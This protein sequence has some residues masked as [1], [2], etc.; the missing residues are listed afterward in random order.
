M[1]P[2]AQTFRVSEI[3]GCFI[4]KIDLFFAKKDSILPVKVEI[5]TVRNGY[6][7]NIVLP[8]S[9][10]VVE[11]EDVNIAAADSSAVATGI[12][13]SL[14]VSL[15]I[16]PTTFTFDSPV[17]VKEGTEYAIIVSSKSTDYRIWISQQ[18]EID[19]GGG[20]RT[21]SPTPEGGVLFKSQNGST[22]NSIQTQDI[23]FTIYKCNFSSTTG[24]VTLV[25]DN[26]DDIPDTT[27]LAEDGTTIVYG[28]RLKSNPLKLTN[29]STVMQVLHRSHGMYSTTNNV[30]ITGASSGIT[31]TL[32]TGITA[33]GNLTLT[34][35]TGFDPSNLQVSSVDQMFIKIDNEIIRGTL[36]SLAFTSNSRG[37]DG[38]TAASHATGATIELYQ[39][40]EVPLTEI[41]KTHTAIAN[42]D[43]DSYTVSLTT[44]PTVAGASTI[45]EAGGINTIA[46]E[47][48]RYDTFRT[49]LNILELPNTNVTARIRTTSGTSPS[50]SEASFVTKSNSEAFDLNKNIDLDATSIVCSTINQT[51]ELSGAKSLF[52]PITLVT[53]NR[54][55]S[56][57]ID[58]ATM[59][60]LAVANQLNSIDSSSDVYANYNASTEPEGDNNA[61]IYITKKIA[62]Q[63]PATALKVF[64]AGNIQGTSEVEVLFK[65]LRTDSSDDFDDI[66]YE[67]FNT[68]G[69]PD[70]AVAKSLASTDF[71]DYFYSAGVKD[72]GI[73][74]TLPE[75]AQFA[76]KLVFKGTNAAQPPR[77]KDFRAIAL[78][79]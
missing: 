25:N 2:L 11:S 41:N 18:G 40:A 36:S 20:K 19:V 16:T 73:G 3:D 32:T 72:D 5:R 27:K 59:S 50:G 66:G 45:A 63:N 10:K 14:E 53:N 1:N 76:I 69:S 24:T 37:H 8:F 28:H 61:A 52:I 26:V 9:S 79:I 56:P 51:N 64:F 21:I 54:N 75:F 12:E 71:Q 57:I 74:D 15:G 78:A 67:F 38:T 31:T 58:T 29:T 48:W 46:S 70:D 55:I 6:P 17:Y 68:D 33:T 43:I 22:F 49:Q 44:A 30:T 60:M 13:N 34:S 42:I 62:L 77:I 47:N 35:A 39:L 65:I 4:P 7:T 23:K